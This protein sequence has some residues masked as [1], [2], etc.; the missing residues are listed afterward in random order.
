MSFR[1]LVAAAGA[2]ALALTLSA[3]CQAQFRRTFVPFGYYYPFA[4]SP[5]QYPLYNPYA[6]GSGTRIYITPPAAPAESSSASSY[7]QPR[8]EPRPRIQ[9]FDA[10]GNEYLPG[11]QTKVEKIQPVTIHKYL[12][13]LPSEAP[14]QF[15]V[16]VPEGAE[17]WV[18]GVKTSQS[19]TTRKLASPDLKPDQD[20]VY[21]MRAQ[22]HEQGRLFTET[23]RVTFQA[24][25]E[26]KVDFTARPTANPGVDKL[27]MPKPA[28]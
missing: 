15:E 21:E 27:P 10:N 13:K 23:H 18:D 6:R 20:Y 19:G 9:E 17:L 5:W 26:V 24:G 25:D 2:T 12:E 1:W 11:T 22:W 14:T 16:R 3:P 4:Y 8:P 7:A 28:K